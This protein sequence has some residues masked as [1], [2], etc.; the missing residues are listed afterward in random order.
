MRV[1][2]RPLR[3]YEGQKLQRMKRQRSNTVNALHA[4]VI[5]L[6]RG[7][8]RPAQ[9]AQGC[10]YSPTWVR[11]LIHRFNAGGIPAITWCPYLCSPAEPR[12]FMADLIQQITQVALA[13]PKILIGLSVWSLS[14]LRQYLIEQGI[15]GAISLEWLRQLLR[16]HRIRWR[17]AKTWKEST[18]PQFWPKFRRLQ[19]LYRQCPAGGV[20]LCVDEFGPLNLQPRL[21]KHYAA[22]GHVDRQRA[23]YTR[24]GGVRHLLAVY[25]L[26][27]NQLQGRFV[28]R[29]NRRT[30]LAFLQW[31]RSLYPAELTLHIVLDNA[32]WHGVAEVLAYAAAHKLVFYWTP[33]GAS[34]L[35]RIEC[36]FT[37]LR[38]F[39][40][41]N[42][43]YREHRALRAAIQRYLSWRN[44]QRR[45]SLLAWKEY[46]DS[47]EAIPA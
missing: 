46:Q 32:G 15:V 14:K 45:I 27:R 17:H 36:H 19:Q 26:E 7:G 37:A 33:T 41:D 1:V 9:I 10:G 44:G 3:P 22:I 2:L 35:N 23:A 39:V 34:W 24:T 30:F 42:S 16:R 43:D 38:K 40:L 25:D 6:A 8:L 5:R 29:K 11:V 20:R 12:K 47:L 21:G 28:R 4:R 31:V 18:D 13:S